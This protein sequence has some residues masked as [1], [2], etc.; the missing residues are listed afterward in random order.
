M[1]FFSTVTTVLFLSSASAYAQQQGGSSE[2]LDLDVN[3]GASTFTA[4][5]RPGG[6]VYIDVM[7]V[8]SVTEMEI[9]GQ[10]IDSSTNMHV[11]SEMKVTDLTTGG[12]AICTDVKRFSMS[13]ESLGAQILSCDTEDRNTKSQDECAP[14]FAL[15]GQSSHFVIDDEGTVAAADYGALEDDM[16]ESSSSSGS[17]SALTKAGPS[18]QLAQT[19]RLLK[20]IP[21]HPVLP[22]DK[23]D[24]SV[25]MGANGNFE[26]TSTLL[27]F[28]IYNGHDCAV[29]STAGSLYIDAQT[30][31]DSM[32]MEGFMSDVNI[33]DATMKTTMYW[34]NTAKLA[35]W[36]ETALSMIIEMKNPFDESKMSVPVD[37]VI[38]NTADV[39]V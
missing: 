6:F 8:A 2:V 17:S 11:E 27:G 10:H 23:W 4:A 14:L 39:K 19:S 25:D 26:G 36:S 29:I 1:K 33:R 3:R 35:R 28:K 20:F 30:M 15:V 21:S 38:T 13:I 24:A 22:G 7:D 16:E 12:K 34:D 32:G 18:E 9:A 31:A 5:T 37:E